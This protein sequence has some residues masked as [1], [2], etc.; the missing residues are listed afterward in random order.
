[1]KLVQLLFCVANFSEKE[2]SFGFNLNHCNVV[3]RF[4]RLCPISQKVEALKA[5]NYK[6]YKIVENNEEQTPV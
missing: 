3:F 2:T 1:M 6:V 4:F 5:Y